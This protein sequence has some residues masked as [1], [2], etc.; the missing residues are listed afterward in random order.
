M[1]MMVEQNTEQRLFRA[2]EVMAHAHISFRQLD[3]WTRNG[4]L[5]AALDADGS[6][7]RRLFTATEVLVASALGACSNLGMLV[8]T[9]LTA[10]M[11]AHI[12]TYGVGKVFRY[13]GF[14]AI[15]INRLLVANDAQVGTTQP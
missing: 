9:D 1:D 3:H 8:D 12:R 2:G 4:L 6:G 15:D 14:L 10:A 11:A 5:V 7:S 13:G